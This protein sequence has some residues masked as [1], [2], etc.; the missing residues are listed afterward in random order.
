MAN[1]IFSEGS[2]VNESV[3]GASQAP[4][5][6]FLE[7]RAEAFE[8][9]SMLKHMVSMG[10]SKNWGEKYTSMTAMDGFQPGGAAKTRQPLKPNAAAPNKNSRLDMWFIA[11][12]LFTAA[13]TSRNSRFTFARFA[14]SIIHSPSKS[15]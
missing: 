14:V 1:I 3:Y 5:R 2:G 4:I 11:P 15:I 12:L 13:F 8:A 9:Q 10:K 7:K 6:M